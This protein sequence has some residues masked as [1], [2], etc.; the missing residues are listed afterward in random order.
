M[1]HA[2]YEAIQVS[3]GGNLRFSPEL[4]ETQA[5]KESG[6]KSRFRESGRFSGEMT[7]SVR[8]GLERFLADF[9]RSSR[10]AALVVGWAM[11][12]GCGAS[13]VKDRWWQSKV[14]CAARGGAWVTDKWM[15]DVTSLSYFCVV[16]LDRQPVEAGR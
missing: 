2:S 3:V 14:E 4:T 13:A 16:K 9:R 11:G 12:S 7:Q 10:W 1:G 6:G 5:H 8:V 15:W